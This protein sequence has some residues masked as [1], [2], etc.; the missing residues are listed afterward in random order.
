[1]KVRENKIE[2][3]KVPLDQVIGNILEV[4]WVSN[5][6]RYHTRLDCFIQHVE[7]R[8]EKQEIEYQ[9]V[10]QYLLSHYTIE[11]EKIFYEE[12]VRDTKVEYTWEIKHDLAP[13]S[14]VYT[15]KTIVQEGQWYEEKILKTISNRYGIEIQKSCKKYRYKATFLNNQVSLIINREKEKIDKANVTISSDKMKY[16]VQFSVLAPRKK[17]DFYLL[18]LLIEPDT[19]K[20]V[21][22]KMGILLKQKIYQNA[23]YHVL[24][25]EKE[26]L[27]KL[28]FFEPLTEKQFSQ[29]ISFAKGRDTRYYLEEIGGEERFRW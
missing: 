16:Q 2:T 9:L 4:L 6:I 18:D 26:K 12:Q 27:E 1:M 3:P 21:L 28:Q 8:Y 13:D 17:G 7:D 5:K 15:I 20:R 24:Q 23:S 22:E 25:K 10:K 11:N 19:I 29:S 14:F